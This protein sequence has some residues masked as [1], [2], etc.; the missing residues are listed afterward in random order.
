MSHIGR[1]G[2]DIGGKTPWRRVLE[3]IEESRDEWIRWR[4]GQ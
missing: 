3:A 2:K 4:R 1:I